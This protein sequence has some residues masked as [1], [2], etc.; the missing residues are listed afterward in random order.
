MKDIDKDA[1]KSELVK[2]ELKRNKHQA[3]RAVLEMFVNTS[4]MMMNN[5]VNMEPSPRTAED[6]R[7]K[8]MIIEYTNLRKYVNESLLNVSRVKACSVPLIGDAWEYKQFNKAADIAKKA[9]QVPVVEP[10]TN[11]ILSFRER[12]LK[13]DMDAA[14]AFAALAQAQVNP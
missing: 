3:I 5:L 13:T 14:A 6:E 8:N 10:P 11:R 1:M 12:E 9:P 2:R 7:I 4:I